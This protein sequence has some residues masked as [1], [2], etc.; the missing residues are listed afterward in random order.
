MGAG[1]EWPQT[2]GSIIPREIV[3]LHATLYGRGPTK[4]KT[5]VHADYVL[6]ALENVFT[7]AESTLI[8]AGKQDLV[9]ETR[10]A[11]QDATRDVFVAIVGPPAGRRVRAFPL[12]DRR[13]VE[14][15]RRGLPARVRARGRD[16]AARPS[17]RGPLTDV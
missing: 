15:C 11:F 3:Q 9:R 12:S 14:H 4:A 10:V 2:A 7:P 16:D 13:R 1:K 6:C 17:R 8:D 5:H